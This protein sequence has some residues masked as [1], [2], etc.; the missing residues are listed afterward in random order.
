MEVFVIM[1]Q[2][3]FY[4][5]SQRQHTL[6][7]LFE[8]YLHS[9]MRSN[10]LPRKG[11]LCLYDEQNNTW[12]LIVIGAYICYTFIMIKNRLQVYIGSKFLET[13]NEV[14]VGETAVYW[15][16]KMQFIVRVR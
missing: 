16:S 15:S 1:I 14:A 7:L 5:K 8:D 9:L 3:I 4:L 13:S 6:R 10:F 2:S 11:L 12:L